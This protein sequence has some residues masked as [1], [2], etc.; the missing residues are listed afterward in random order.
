MKVG[1]ALAWLLPLLNQGGESQVDV[2]GQSATIYLFNFL[3]QLI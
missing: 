1:E 2:D 3:M